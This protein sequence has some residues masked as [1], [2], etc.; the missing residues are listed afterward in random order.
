MS[1]TKDKING[2]ALVCKRCGRGSDVD[3][4]GEWIYT[5]S[6]KYTNCPNCKTSVNVSKSKKY[7]EKTQSPGI[8]LVCPKCGRGKDSDPLGDWN[9]KGKS[10]HFTTC[11]SCRGPVH[12]KRNTKK[13]GEVS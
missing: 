13:V 2:V 8:K 10:K 1:K 4:K 11:P 3:P 7:P 9:Y 6:R 5:G 12:V